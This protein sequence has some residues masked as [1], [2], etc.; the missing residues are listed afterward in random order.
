MQIL[1]LILSSFFSI[2][3]LMKVSPTPTRYVIHTVCPSKFI[4][5]AM[6]SRLRNM[7]VESQQKH[8]SFDN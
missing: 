2:S 8:G 1:L 4:V 6:A 3:E 7:G 5:L